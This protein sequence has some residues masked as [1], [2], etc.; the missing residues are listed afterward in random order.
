[1]DKKLVFRSKVDWWVW[2]VMLSLTATIL[3]VAVSV[4]W[5]VTVL[6][7]VLVLGLLGVGFFGCWYEIDRGTLIVY[8]LCRPM[9]LPIGKIAEVR[10]CKGFVAGPAMSLTRLS[11]KFSDRSVLKSSMPIEISPLD[12]DGFVAALLAVNP[13]IRVMK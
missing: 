2:C 9:R 3:A 7:T 13:S 4:S 5:I 11:I 1:M 8:N 10:Y 6:Y 12:R